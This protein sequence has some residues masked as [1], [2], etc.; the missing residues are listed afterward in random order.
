MDNQIAK[1]LWIVKP[2]WNIYLQ[3]NYHCKDL[4]IK[5]KLLIFRIQIKN[6]SRCNSWLKKSLKRSLNWI[7][8]QT[9][10]WHPF[11]SLGVSIGTWKVPISTW[12]V[13]IGTSKVL[14]G[15]KAQLGLRTPTNWDKAYLFRIFRDKDT[16]QFIS[17]LIQ[18]IF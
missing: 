14:T 10:T 1:K 15:P 4:N 8:T 11:G 16:F 7:K 12:Q 3:D 18:L 2:F 6:T 17:D 5:K 9:R 13:L